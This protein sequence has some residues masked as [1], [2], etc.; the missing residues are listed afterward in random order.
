VADDV[1]MTSRMAT[2][3]PRLASKNFKQCQQCAVSD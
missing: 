1:A 3:A 2:E